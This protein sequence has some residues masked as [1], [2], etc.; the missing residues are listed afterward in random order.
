VTSIKVADMDLG[1]T[2]RTVLAE[3]RGY[4]VGL[5]L[6]GGYEI[7]IESARVPA[8]LAGLVVTVGTAE[9]G[10]L[11]LDFDDDTTLAVAPDPEFEAWTLAGP[12]GF[13]VVCSPGGE[14]SVWPA[15]SL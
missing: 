4:T 5:I 11:R 7:R 12:D 9:N 14:L 8:D 1:L 2:G 13:K 3:D 10:T 6:S 15:Q